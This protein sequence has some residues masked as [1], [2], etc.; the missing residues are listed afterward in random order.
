MKI[1]DTKSNKVIGDVVGGS[2]WSVSQACHKLMYDYREAHLDEIDF[3][4]DIPGEPLAEY[5]R[6][7]FGGSYAHGC[8]ILGTGVTYMYED[9]RL[10][11]DLTPVE[12]YEKTLSLERLPFMKMPHTMRRMYAEKPT[13]E[14]ETITMTA[15]D[16][17]YLAK[18]GQ[19]H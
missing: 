9:L 8:L 11:M 3:N 10:E 18:I 16:A 12:V 2:E 5:D 1:I 17:A 4:G 7:T 19:I 13:G 15:E 6:I 14:Y